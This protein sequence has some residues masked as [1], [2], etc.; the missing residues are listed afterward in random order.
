[1]TGRKIL[2]ISRHDYRTGWRAGRHFLADAFRDL[3]A[4]VQF[5]SVGFSALSMLS[6]DHRKN[7]F[8]RANTWQEVAGVNCFLWRSPVH[9][10][11]RGLGKFEGLTNSLF[12]WWVGS[13]C[14]A[15]DEAA[16]DADLIIVESG[17]SAALIGRVRKSAPD[18]KIIYFVAD[19]L[20][21]IGAHPFIAAQLYSDRHAIDRIV[22][23]ARAMAP[24][25][26]D[27]GCP[28]HFVPHGV[29]KSDFDGIGASPYETSRNIATVGS[30]LFD[31]SFFTIAAGAFPDVHFHLIG[32]PGIEG[33]LDNVT[34]YGRMPFRD[35]LP[36]LKHADAGVAPYRF[37][38]DAAY[39]ADS[40]LK[41]MQYEYLQLPAVC[42]DFAVG[43][44][45]NRH[46][47]EPGE[48]E[49]ILR[50]IT[51]AL[52][53]TFTNEA[54]DVLDWKDVADRLLALDEDQPLINS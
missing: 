52:G 30:M 29:S 11:G 38:S 54:S 53:G 41:L 26:E 22:V 14:K 1:M 37:R 6:D 28:V 35:T 5:F 25:F 49:T 7:L 2:L 21:T 24:H 20:D 23:V 48:P 16:R 45:I 3:G 39:L 44:K 10:F 43:D 12:R 18:A 36:Y 19:L 15:L 47:Y 27:F 40:S 8:A 51:A 34:E 17:I 4:S 31:A 46:G 33:N 42:P 50:A 9:P 32:T 13:A